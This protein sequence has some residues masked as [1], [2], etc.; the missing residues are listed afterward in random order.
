MHLFLERQQKAHRGAIR[1]CMS[2]IVTLRTR[3][4]ERALNMLKT[5]GQHAENI[6]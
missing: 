3:P 5:H 2:Q 1:F 4:L 6:F